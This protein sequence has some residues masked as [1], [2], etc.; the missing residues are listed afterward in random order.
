MNPC[1]S[2]NMLKSPPRNMGGYMPALINLIGTRFGRLVVVSRAPGNDN[3]GKA[4]WACECDCGQSA[5][6]RGHSLRCGETTSCGCYR[7]EVTAAQSRILHLRHGGA[8]TPE[9]AAWANMLGRCENPNDQ[10]YKGY[11]GRGIDVCEEWQNSFEAFRGCVGPR[12]SADHSIGRIDNDR[13][14]EP[15]NVRWETRV[16]Q[17]NNRRSSVLITYRGETLTAAQW[18]RRAGLASGDL[19][20]MRI[21]K[22][23]RPTDAVRFAMSFGRREKEKGNA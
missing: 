22:G 2:P 12:P 13:G 15:G 10:A 6:V 21:R 3:E 4:M 11:G 9:Y 14:Y 7:R 18:G 19:I 16:E 20:T 5:V 1:E 8:R 23:W 17:S